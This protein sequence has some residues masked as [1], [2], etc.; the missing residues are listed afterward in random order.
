VNRG[1]PPDLKEESKSL[2][3]GE[4]TFRKKGD[5]LLQCWMD[6]RVVNM[7]STI[8]NSSMGGVQ[9]R[10]GQVKKP[11]CIAP[12]L[13]YH[14]FSTLISLIVEPGSREEQRFDSDSVCCV[15]KLP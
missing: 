6:A 1:L 13:L 15:H 11:N 3:R 4:T 2:K 10:H 14:F 9:R 8:H 12:P 7:I 5:I